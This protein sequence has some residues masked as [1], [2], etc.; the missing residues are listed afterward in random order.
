MKRNGRLGNEL[1]DFKNKLLDSNITGYVSIYL[2]LG[3]PAVSGKTLFKNVTNILCIGEYSISF[4][5][6]TL[7]NDESDSLSFAY[8][9]LFAFKINNADK[10]SDVKNTLVQKLAEHNPPIIVTPDT[11]RLRERNALHPGQVI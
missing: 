6:G 4:C 2:Q 5:L 10:V 8:E 7:L 11:I 9:D 1:R 3:V